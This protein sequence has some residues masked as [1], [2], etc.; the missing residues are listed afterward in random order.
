MALLHPKLAQPA[1]VILLKA[2][3]SE[4][5]QWLSNKEHVSYIEN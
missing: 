1:G 3:D 5:S 4:L 2:K